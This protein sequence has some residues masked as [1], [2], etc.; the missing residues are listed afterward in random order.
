MAP[1]INTTWLALAGP[2]VVNAGVDNSTW[3]DHTDIQPTMLALLGLRGD[4]APDGR[5][6][7]EVIDS[8]ALP[9]AMLSNYPL[10]AELGQVY[11]QI[12]AAVGEFGLGPRDTTAGSAVGARSAPGVPGGR[13]PG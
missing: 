5:V 12:E 8:S 7:S 13:P 9:P 6:L 3:S 2:G 4:Y 11:T 1:E 10:L